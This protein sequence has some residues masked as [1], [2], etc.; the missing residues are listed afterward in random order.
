MISQMLVYKKYDY[1]YI[2]IYIQRLVQSHSPDLG[3]LWFE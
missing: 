1:T 3:L 2:V